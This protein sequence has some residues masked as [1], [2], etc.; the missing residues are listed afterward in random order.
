V[1]QTRAGPG[2]VWIHGQRSHPQAAI[3]A[4]E[5]PLRG[6]PQVARTELDGVVPVTREE[7][8]DDGL[9][10][11][12]KHRFEQ[13]KQDKARAGEGR[14]YRRVGREVKNAVL[15][16]GKDCVQESVERASILN[17]KYVSYLGAWMPF[18]LLLWTPGA[19]SASS[20]LELTQYRSRLP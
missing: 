1:L 19:R 4:L 12:D 5:A 3:D 17:E 13:A 6:K 18:A 11:Q 9:A 7:L 10:D 2:G 8:G 14:R 16:D 20:F 15:C